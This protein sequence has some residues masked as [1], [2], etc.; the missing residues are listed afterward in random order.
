MFQFHD[1]LPGSSIEIV[2]DDAKQI[3]GQVLTEGQLLMKGLLHSLTQQ[4][5]ISSV[6]SSQLQL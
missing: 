5:I 1:V 4:V 2:H 6:V 3:Y